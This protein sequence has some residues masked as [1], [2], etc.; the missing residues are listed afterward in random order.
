MSKESG[1]T[2]FF[3]SGSAAWDWAGWLRVFRC[4]SQMAN[5]GSS[6]IDVRDGGLF[7][8]CKALKNKNTWGPNLSYARFFLVIAVSYIS[9]LNK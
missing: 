3:V 4:S 9:L 7:V 6:K 1:W 8:S 5:G 2:L